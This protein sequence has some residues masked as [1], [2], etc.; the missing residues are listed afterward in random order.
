MSEPKI[1]S[2]CED[3]EWYAV[4]KWDNVCGHVAKYTDLKEI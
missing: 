2:F 4:H 1:E 3:G